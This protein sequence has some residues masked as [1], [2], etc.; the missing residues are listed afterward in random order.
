MAKIFVI[1]R[2]RTETAN[3]FIESLETDQQP[4]YP[5]L[6]YEPS[7]RNL[8][9]IWA[10]FLRLQPDLVYFILEHDE[11][12]WMEK[13]LVETIGALPHQ[14]IAV[15]F[16]GFLNQ[17]K[18]KGL[19]T[20]LKRADLVTLPSRQNLADLRGISSSS[21]RQLR[22]LLA[23][24]PALNAL[25]TDVDH[26][27]EEVLSAVAN[28]KLWIAPWDPAYVKE[29]LNFFEDVAKEKNW[30]FL[31]DRSQWTFHEH[32]EFQALFDSWKN[33]P[34]W[35]S[36]LN[37]TETLKLLKEAEVLVLAGL[38]IA[39]SQFVDLASLSAMAGVFVILDTHQIELMSGLWA[40][41]ENCT[42]LDR[43]HYSQ[44]LENRW[45]SGALVP[46]SFKRKVRTPSLVL[47]QSLNELNRWIA[48]ALADRKQA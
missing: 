26:K 13:A 48:K 23:P 10:S 46:T 2:E 28:R 19:K 21:K 43:D 25:E 1:S 47:D 20:L 34:L 7:A 32:K 41:N 33:K 29:N 11:L 12:N 37:K 15:S 17:K 14:P 22:T 39:P 35:S 45:T 18:S 16:L 6:T 5:H 27:S 40:V 44:Q 3:S 4:V 42:L 8:L 30:I 9:M 36:H 31:G 38:S 24:L